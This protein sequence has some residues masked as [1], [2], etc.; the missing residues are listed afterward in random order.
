[1]AQVTLQQLL[2]AMVEQDASDLHVTVGS[3]PQLR[4]GGV[5]SKVKTDVLASTDTKNLCYGVLTEIG[6][7]HV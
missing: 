3:P 7:A 4:I 6:R 5:M 1:M 2:K